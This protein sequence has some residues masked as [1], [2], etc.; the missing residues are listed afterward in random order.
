MGSKSGVGRW[1]QTRKS[2]HHSA[3]M[4][5]ALMLIFVSSARLNEAS[6]TTQESESELCSVS[7]SKGAENAIFRFAPP[8]PWPF[9]ILFL[10]NFTFS[11]FMF[12]HDIYGT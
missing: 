7:L 11:D 9:Q 2:P 6:R 1:V 10:Q 3:A 12:I 4:K 8:Y 5:R